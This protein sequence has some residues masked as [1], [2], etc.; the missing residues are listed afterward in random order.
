MQTK[1]V[2]TSFLLHR[3]ED[4]DRILLLR[5]SQR[6]KT[7]KGY[8]AAV[9]GYLEPGATPEE[10]ARTEIAEETG[11]GPENVYLLAQG[12]EVHAPDPPTD[13]EWVVHPVLFQVTDPGKVRLDWEH[14]ES[15]WIA[16]DE[17]GEFQT[18]PHLAEALAAVYSS[19]ESANW[20]E[21]QRRIARLREDRERGATAIAEEAALLLAQVAES[22]WLEPMERLAAA[23]R[24]VAHARPVMAS[25]RNIALAVL[26]TAHSASGNHMKAAARSARRLAHLSV[27]SSATIALRAQ[28]VLHGTVFTLSSSS[29]VRQA[30]EKAAPP[31]ERVIV[32]ESRPGQEGFR[33][34]EH[35]AGLGISVEVV[36]DAQT[37]AALRRCTVA[38]IGADAV[39]ADGAAINKVGS[40]LAALA[41]R[42]ATVPFYVL[43]DTMKLAPWTLLTV[44]PEVWE[45]GG[46]QETSP[47]TPADSRAVDPL[48]E[49]VPA[50]LIARYVNEEGF[51]TPEQ[52]AS[53][54][55][56][57][58]A[59]WARLD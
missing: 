10:Q 17:I 36:A 8:W 51:R 30:L 18:V 56:G 16:P 55:H 22:P 20:Q 31:L 21:I 6:V 13:T 28:P 2:V 58:A 19:P 46:A 48:F 9:S 12:E 57:L 49:G 40:L 1:H 44:P 47:E 54:A 45:S 27:G 7:H 39:L 53:L 23:C 26:E 29:A 59:A 11:L 42:E 52:M 25:L 5:R 43:A 50:Y 35:L 32:A 4:G 34:A 38:I 14:V 41:A 24:A 15:R 33:L 3:S 37:A